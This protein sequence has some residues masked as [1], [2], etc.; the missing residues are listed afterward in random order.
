[1]TGMTRNFS[2]LVRLTWESHLDKFCVPSTSSTAFRVVWEAF[3]AE[4]MTSCAVNASIWHI[5]E[6]P[7]VGPLFLNAIPFVWLLTIHRVCEKSADSR[8]PAA[9]CSSA[10]LSRIQTQTAQDTCIP[11]YEPVKQRFWLF[12]FFLSRNST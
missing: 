10:V 11:L 2:A 9:K 7:L 6:M 5:D 1:M 3:L 12:A 8:F 4:K